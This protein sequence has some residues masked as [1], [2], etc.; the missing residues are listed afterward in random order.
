M[1]R[2]THPIRFFDWVGREPGG[3][4]PK[5]T[6]KLRDNGTDQPELVIQYVAP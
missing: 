2:K 3:G 1:V 5:T 4:N 6:V